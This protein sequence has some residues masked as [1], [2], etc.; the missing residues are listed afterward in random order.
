MKP[1]KQARA[2]WS[3]GMGAMKASEQKSEM[4]SLPVGSCQLL[5]LKRARWGTEMRFLAAHLSQPCLAILPHHPTLFPAAILKS[6]PVVHF[7]FCLLV[8]FSFLFLSFF[9]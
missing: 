9:R 1:E 8:I 7:G 5:C 4:T 2:D 3:E 6:S